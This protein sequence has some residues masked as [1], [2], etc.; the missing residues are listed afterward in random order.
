MTS[1]W[2]YFYRWLS[3]TLSTFTVGPL[4]FTVTWLAFVLWM[5][6][7]VLVVFT[8]LRGK[9]HHLAHSLV[10]EPIMLALTPST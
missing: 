4:T 7:L 2:P 3:S 1:L 8:Q 6:A 5:V 9:K 10:N